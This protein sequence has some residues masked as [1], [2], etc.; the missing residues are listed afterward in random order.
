MDGGREINADSL[1]AAYKEL[2]GFDPPGEVIKRLE[3]ISRI[4]DIK[5]DDVVWS[6]FLGMELYDRVYEKQI[7]RLE[8]TLE[9]FSQRT[10]VQGWI[11]LSIAILGAVF[12]GL[13]CFLGGYCLGA[14]RS[15]AW[16][17]PQHPLASIL[18]APA[19]WIVVLTIS[20]WAGHYVFRQIK[21]FTSGRDQ[22]LKSTPKKAGPIGNIKLILSLA[23]LMLSAGIILSFLI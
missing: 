14:G 21:D 6:I 13:I 11:W 22:S 10:P 19:G 4:L 20:P 16:M 17:V 15:P 7:E 1:K 18:L 23:A 9:N 2:V 8:S 12:L 5:P 3:N